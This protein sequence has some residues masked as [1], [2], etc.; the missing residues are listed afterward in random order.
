[1][2]NFFVDEQKKNFIINKK[3]AS[4]I[5]LKI[6]DESLGFVEVIRKHGTFMF[7]PTTSMS[8]AW[9]VALQLG[10][11]DLMAMPNDQWAA[12]FGNIQARSNTA[13]MAIC[14]A[15]LKVIKQL[16]GDGS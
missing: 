4:A 2:F 3:I 14:K 13:Q 16:D 9:T 11:T 10:L 6:H 7:S 1:V 8:D 12:W 5:G 15:A